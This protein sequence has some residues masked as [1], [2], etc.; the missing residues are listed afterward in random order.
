MK[1]TRINNRREVDIKCE[2]VYLNLNDNNYIL[3]ESFG[4]LL[5]HSSDGKIIVRPK[6]GNEISVDAEV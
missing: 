6:V 5:I 1:I 2:S 3:T 4:E